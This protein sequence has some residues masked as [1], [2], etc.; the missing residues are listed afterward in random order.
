MNFCQFSSKDAKIPGHFVCYENTMAKK[1]EFNPDE[2]DCLDE[3]DELLSDS[4]IVLTTRSA[5]TEDSKTGAGK[6]HKDT[7]KTHI[8]VKIE[9]EDDEPFL[10]AAAFEDELVLNDILQNPYDKQ[11]FQKLS[12][13]DN[14]ELTQEELAFKRQ[15]ED[16]FE[17]LE[18]EKNANK[19]DGVRVYQTDSSPSR[20]WRFH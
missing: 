13:R 9:Y 16:L 4:S 20:P 18:M 14:N 10:E 12:D 2:W 5:S 15:I 8:S 3:N 7:S 17:L 6:K 19:N 11:T 1:L